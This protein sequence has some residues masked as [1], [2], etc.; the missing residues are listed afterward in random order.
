MWGSITSRQIRIRIRSS[1]SSLGSPPSPFL[2][3]STFVYRKQSK[4]YSRTVTSGIRAAILEY[5]RPRYQTKAAQRIMTLEE[6][7]AALVTAVN[8]GRAA[9]DAKLS[10]L[11]TAVDN[12]KPVVMDLQA[13][14]EALQIRVDRFAPYFEGSSSSTPTATPGADPDIERGGRASPRR[15]R[16][17]RQTLRA[18]W[19]PQATQHRGRCSRS[20][21]PGTSSGHR[22]ESTAQNRARFTGSI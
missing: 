3:V 19:P 14:V 8:E 20:S 21:T 5:Q 7:L 12:W 22:C 1:A 10:T 13:Q 15:R 17:P 4:S 9:T 18:R 6:Q 16:H 11:Q 2:L